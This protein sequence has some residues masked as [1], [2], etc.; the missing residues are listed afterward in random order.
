MYLP[1][2]RLQITDETINIAFSGSLVDYVLVVIVAKSPRQLLVV[3]LGLV[4]ANPPSPGHLIGI[5]QFELPTVARPGDE[6]LTRLVRQ[7]FQ[8]KLP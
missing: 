1:Q 7:Q 4:L 2:Q 3:H 8:E 6:R 5:G